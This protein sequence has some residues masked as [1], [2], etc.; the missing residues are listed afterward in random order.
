MAQTCEHCCTRIENL[1]VKFGAA[2]ILKD[3]DLHVNC[4]EL[5]AIVGPNGA[6]KTTLLRAMLQ[7]VPY[8]GSI[9]F[10]VKGR[11]NNRPR[12]GYVPQKLNYDLD[13]P[14]SVLDL[15]AIA[16]SND[17][18][19]LRVRQT[20]RE[21]IRESLASVSAGHLLDKRIG[22]LSGGE[23]QRVLLAMAMTPEPDLLLLDEPMSGVDARGLSLFYEIA[24][25]LSKT[26]DVTILLVTHDLIGVA[27][28]ADRMVLINNSIIASGRPQEVLSDERLVKTLGPSLWNISKLP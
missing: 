17:P 23:L 21:E 6:G 5:I 1:N 26:K 10:Q 28:H 24:G 16:V 3:V 9:K 19:W 8:T 14:V 11:I 2:H 20:L 4:G 12:I 27:P 22:E 25:S 18:V 15:I 13:S 7:E